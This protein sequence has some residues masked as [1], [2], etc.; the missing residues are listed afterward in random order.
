GRALV[1]V[2]KLWLKLGERIQLF[3]ASVLAALPDQMTQSIMAS[4]GGAGNGGMSRSRGRPRERMPVRPARPIDRA[5]A[6]IL[7]E[8]PAR[9]QVWR[10]F[11]FLAWKLGC[12]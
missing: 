6:S 7:R 2:A 3:H 5:S 12:S 8:S 9:R 1:A 4:A 11:K 10:F